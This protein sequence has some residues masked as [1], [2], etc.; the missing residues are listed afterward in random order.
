MSTTA[1]EHERTAERRCSLRYVL[2]RRAVIMSDT[3]DTLSS[4]RV[5]RANVNI[6]PFQDLYVGPPVA[7]KVILGIAALH[8]NSRHPSRELTMRG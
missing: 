4:A 5:R 6:S 3:V 7:R 2:H 8:D 1:H